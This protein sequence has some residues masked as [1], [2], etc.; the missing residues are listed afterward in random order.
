MALIA[1]MVRIA[2]AIIIIPTHLTCLA[3][4]TMELI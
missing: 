2:V 3:Q 1:Q 4:P